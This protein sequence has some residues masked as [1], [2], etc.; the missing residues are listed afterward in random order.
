MRL[1]MHTARF[2]NVTGSIGVRHSGRTVVYSTTNPF[3]FSGRVLLQTGEGSYRVV[4]R[5]HDQLPAASSRL[6]IDRTRYQ[7]R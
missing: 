7:R 6:A 4:G 5:H 2:F 1:D 3:L